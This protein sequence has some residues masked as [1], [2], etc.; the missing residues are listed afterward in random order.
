VTEAATMIYFETTVVNDQ[1]QE[2]ESYVDDARTTQE[3]LELARIAFRH[4]HP[5]KDPNKHQFKAR[6][7]KDGAAV[8]EYGR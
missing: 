5:D 7:H 2:V 3:A 6:I 1:G 8:L 4:H